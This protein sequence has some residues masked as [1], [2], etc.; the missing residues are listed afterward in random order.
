[1]DLSSAVTATVS[2]LRRRPADLIPFYLL[3]TAVPVIAR[4]GLLVA[5]AGVYL[6]FE[7]TGRLATAREAL[8]ELDLTPPDVEDPEAVQAWGESLAPALEPLASP[9]ALL[10]ITA[11][12]AAT[13]V[14]ALLAYAAVSAGQMSAVVARLRDERGLT[15]GIAGVRRRW[16]T[17]LG[18][19]L[20]EFLLWIAVLVFASVAVALAFLVN[21][22]AGAAVALVT[23]LVGFVVLLA[24]RILF[25]FAPSAVVVDDS[26]VA[27]SLSG[28][29]GFVRSN[30]A[31]AAAYLVVSV[32]VLVGISSAA[33]AL[34][35][36]GGGA[37]VALVSA[38]VVAPALDLLKTVLYGDYRGT[39]D[40]V[41]PP[42]IRLRD[43]FTGGIRRGWRELLA[44][45]RRAPGLHALTVVIGVGFGAL[46]WLAVEPFVGA[47]TTSIESR[48]VGHIAPTAALNFFGNNWSVAIA[49]SLSGVALVIPALSS[50][51]FNGFALGATAALEENLL[52]LLAFVAPHGI[53][54]IPA[55]FISGALGVHLGLVSWGA[56][57]GR[58]SREAFA[59]AL[60]TAFWVLMGIGV[61]L[62]VAGLIEGFVSPYYWR[63]FV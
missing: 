13:V 2:T 33:S 35:F 52:A 27:G 59:D 17:F 34:A 45:V 3:G 40:P 46:G 26:G 49:T 11:G 42:S 12:T 18:L 57:R 8:A 7:V 61:L 25:A 58:R 56:F 28:A 62:A 54:E 36:L 60:E 37:A 41:D 22:F 19:Y 29:V 16:L 20:A 24:V 23:L 5:L 21:P 47:V 10:L 63:P 9:T 50:I 38:V 15:A 44:F 39:V 14:I 6:H 1:M 4:L 31:D 48:L 30:P 43:Q 55:L 32:G 51:A 53:L